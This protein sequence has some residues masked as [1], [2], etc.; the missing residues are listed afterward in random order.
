MKYLYS[1]LLLM[2]LITWRTSLAEDFKKIH[3]NIKNR[4]VEVCS[5]DPDGTLNVAVRCVY[6][7]VDIPFIAYRADPKIKRKPN[8]VTEIITPINTFRN[9]SSV[10][11][12]FNH[13][14]V[15]IN[16]GMA[17]GR[18]N[19]IVYRPS[20]ETPRKFSPTSG[21]I[22][23][24]KELGNEV[25]EISGYKV[26]DHFCLAH[27][28]DGYP[29]GIAVKITHLF[30]KDHYAVVDT[31]S[32]GFLGMGNTFKFYFTEF[33]NLVKCEEDEKLTLDPAEVIKTS[34]PINDQDPRVNNQ[35]TPKEKIESTT[36][37]PA[38]Q[39]PSATGTSR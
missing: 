17:D 4:V 36:A 28:P 37:T 30:N 11:A 19:I 24:N 23:D 35:Q 18:S 8:E 33:S 3:D 13:A 26:G 27:S 34:A 6:N 15:E 31:V 12:V 38:S 1:S 22:V 5:V 25:N 2:G 10:Y 32:D 16:Y 7:L 21:W 9:E 39:S 20:D 29:K 14:L